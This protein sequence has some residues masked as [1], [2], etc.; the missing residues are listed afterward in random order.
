MSVLAPLL[1]PASW[2]LSPGAADVPLIRHLGLGLLLCSTLALLAWCGA[3]GAEAWRMRE[4]GWAVAL[5][6]VLCVA[7]LGHAGWLLRLWLRPV[8]PLTL[9]WTG[10]VARLRSGEPAGGWRVDEWGA[11]PVDVSLV[12]DWQQV[13]LL[14]VRPWESG[15]LQAWIWLRDRRKACPASPGDVHRLRTLL[16]LPPAMTRP[17]GGEAGGPG[18]GKTAASLAGLVASSTH[19]SN[20]EVTR[21]RRGGVAANP[22]RASSHARQKSLDQPL[23]FEDD[24]PATQVLERWQGDGGE[25]GQSS[26]GRP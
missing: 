5:A 6:L 12:W 18:A 21:T 9:R 4:F 17:D 11:Q 10:P 3:T 23:R 25:L 8:A 2:R 13:M 16:C 19:E 7:G 14:R 24:F 26:G 1:R 22:S 20:T 15:N